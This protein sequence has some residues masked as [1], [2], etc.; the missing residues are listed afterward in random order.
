V[1]AAILGEALDDAGAAAFIADAWGH[2]FPL[3]DPPDYEPAPDRSVAALAERQGRSAEAVGY[4]LLLERDGRALL[5]MPLGGYADGDFRAL[6]ELLTQPDVVLGLGDGGAHCGLLCDAS[7]PTYM[8]SH[9]ARERSRGERLTLELAVNLQ[10]LRTASL[11]GFADRGVVA[12][13]YLADLNVIDADHV[14][15]D[16]PEIVYDLPAGGRRLVQRARGYGATVK[17]GVVVR[18]DDRSTGELPGRLL[19]GAQPAPAG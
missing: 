8:L 5:Y 7:V 4:D 13:G 17:R 2:M 12:P 9:W 14:V 6:A 16:A 11:F 1:R 3:G 10:T 18:E 15:S 19:R